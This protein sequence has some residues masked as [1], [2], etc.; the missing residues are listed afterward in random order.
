[1]L[2]PM[3]P[4]DPRVTPWRADIAAKHLE[5]KVNAARFVEGDAEDL[6]FDD[7]SFDIV[8]SLYGAMFAPRPDYVAHE[9]LRVTSPGGTIVMGNWTPGGFVGRMFKTFSRFIA[10]NG[11]PWSGPFA[12]ARSTCDAIAST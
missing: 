11:M 9:L 1:M 7:G 3:P 6:P 5:G 12:G 10:P 8:T 2:K 4:L